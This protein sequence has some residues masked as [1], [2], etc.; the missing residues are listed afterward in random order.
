VSGGS[1]EEPKKTGKNRWLKLKNAT[2]KKKRLGICG[3]SIKKA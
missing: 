1:P 3:F 2:E